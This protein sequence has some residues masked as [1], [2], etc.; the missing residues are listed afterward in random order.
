MGSCVAEYAQSSLKKHQRYQC[1]PNTKDAGQWAGQPFAF[2]R[3]GFQFYDENHCCI[4]H[5]RVYILHRKGLVRT[6]HVRFRFD[7]SKNNFF[8]R[9]FAATSDSILNPVDAAIS[10]LRRVDM[11]RFQWMNPSE[12]TPCAAHFHI[13]FFVTIP[14]LPTFAICAAWLTQTRHITCGSTS[15]G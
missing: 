10:I 2:L 12:Y 9:K 4:A 11:L 1:I 8:I 5:K 3:A 15:K 13:H 14:S 7:K 6:L